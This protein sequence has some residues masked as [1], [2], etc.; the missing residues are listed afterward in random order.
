MASGAGGLC[1]AI[2]C[3]G[4]GKRLRKAVPGTPKP[5]APVAG[6]PF[7]DFIIAYLLRSGVSDI[8][9]CTGYRSGVIEKHYG[10]GIAGARISFSREKRP[11]GTAGALKLAAARIKSDPFLVLNG[12][13]ICAAD[14]SRL[15][16]FHLK[17]KAKATVVLTK[18]TGRSDVG[19]VVTDAS[20]RVVKFSEKKGHGRGAFINAGIYLLDKKVLALIPELRKY[21]L[22]Y[23]L[24]PGLE[25]CFGFKSWA[26]LLDIGVPERY[27]MA[28][29]IL[30]RKEALT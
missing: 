21:S 17:K 11:L 4:A 10:R 13:S 18:N 16:R 8:V 26:P 29:K 24:F 27:I 14:L 12:D 5:M 19:A 28:E 22:E 20:G 25:G 6:V 7:L 1:A 23:D 2:L 15:L 30:K 3:G 9:L